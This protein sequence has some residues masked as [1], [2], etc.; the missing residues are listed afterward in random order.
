MFVK[1]YAASL[2]ETLVPFKLT[3][4]IFFDRWLP[5]QTQDGLSINVFSLRDEDALIVTP[6]EFQGDVDGHLGPA[7]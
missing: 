7:L 6:A 3:M 1:H 5:G 4:V 2:E